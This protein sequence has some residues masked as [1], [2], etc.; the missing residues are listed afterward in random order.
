MQV[1]VRGCCVPPPDACL[2]HTYCALCIPAYGA[3]D[4]C[5]L[6][7]YCALC[8]PAYGALMHAYCARD[9]GL[10]DVDVS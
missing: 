1:P 9:L 4:A 7:T 6:H 3:P 8:I 5:L 10:R 2:L